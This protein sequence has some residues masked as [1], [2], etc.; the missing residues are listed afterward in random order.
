MIAETEIT[1]SKKLKKHSNFSRGTAYFV[2]RTP[3]NKKYKIASSAPE[4]YVLPHFIAPSYSIA[5]TI[6]AYETF[7]NSIYGKLEELRSLSDNWDGENSPSPSEQTI[8]LAKRT[9]SYLIDRGSI[10]NFSYPLRNGGVQL[11]GDD[12]NVEYEVHPNGTV[13]ELSY[14]QDYNLTSDNTIEL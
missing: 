2:Y 3:F 10:V 8:E 6:Y 1:K 11:E 5:N 4:A 9:A 12:D 14:D 7:K 13:H